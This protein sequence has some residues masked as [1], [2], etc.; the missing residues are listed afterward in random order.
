M[1]T[2][3]RVYMINCY[4]ISDD[5]ET[6]HRLTGLCSF[7]EC[8]IL[9]RVG[10]FPTEDVRSNNR[11]HKYVEASYSY[12]LIYAYQKHDLATY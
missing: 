7:G 8:G 4:R 12:P 6:I 10:P 1:N 3:M 11:R 9:E 5:M 2:S